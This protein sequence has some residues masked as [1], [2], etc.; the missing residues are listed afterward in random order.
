MLAQPIGLQT[1]EL[2]QVRGPASVAFPS[3]T[4]LIDYEKDSK[5][6]ANVTPTRGLAQFV[7]ASVQVSW[8]RLWQDIHNKQQRHIYRAVRL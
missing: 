8:L 3:C 5:V 2:A 6:S 7:R 1:A 4:Q